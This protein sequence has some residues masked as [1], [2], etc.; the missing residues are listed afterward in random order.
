MMYRGIGKGADVASAVADVVSKVVDLIQGIVDD[1]IKVCHLRAR[2][3]KRE[4]EPYAP[5]AAF[6]FSFPFP[7]FQTTNNTHTHRETGSLT[8]IHLS[9]IQRRQAFTQNV[10]ARVR[11]GTGL[12]V[13]MS[14][15]GYTFDG[16]FES[17]TST[18]YNAKIGSDV[19]YVLIDRLVSF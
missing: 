16:T 15:V 8:I 12:N 9:G 4:R 18:K 11:Q 19:R 7:I 10:V 1:D 6:T 2:S 17:R 3:G 5:P 13:V 14:N